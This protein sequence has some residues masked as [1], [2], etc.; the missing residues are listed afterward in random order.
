MA[1]ETLY[2]VRLTSTI[3][4]DI[5]RGTSVLTSHNNMVADGLCAFGPTKSINE[6]H[7]LASKLHKWWPDD[8]EYAIITGYESFGKKGSVG[9]VCSS[10]I[11]IS[12][13][14]F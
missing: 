4:E 1:T 7:E 8:S 14:I 10:P 2:F 6:A 12:K 3:E 5:E 9:T 13:H 11:L